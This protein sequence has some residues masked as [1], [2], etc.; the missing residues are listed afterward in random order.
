MRRREF[1]G[2]LGGA[3]VGWPIAA[4]AQ[5]QERVRRIAVL[6]GLLADDPD[7][8]AQLAVFWQELRQLG[9]VVGRN[10]QIEYRWGAGDTDRIRKGAAELAAIAPDVIF[11][12]SGT[13]MP[14]LQQA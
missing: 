1:F 11:A 4:K 2:V 14:A 5:Q 7:A 9:W 12:T 8:Q 13:V 6:S 3:A 10:L